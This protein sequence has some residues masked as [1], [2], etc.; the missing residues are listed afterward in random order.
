MDTI[1]PGI[2]YWLV[3]GLLWGWFGIIVETFWTMLRKFKNKLFKLPLF[4]PIRRFNRHVYVA[5]LRYIH[6]PL[7]ERWLVWRRIHRVETKS[8]AVSG[9]KIVKKEVHPHRRSPFSLFTETNGW[10]FIMFATGMPLLL[11][12]SKHLLQYHMS[13]CIRFSLYALGFW[14]AELLWGTLI[15]KLGARVP[16]DYSAAKWS[17]CGGLIRLDYFPAWGALGLAVEH[18][19]SYWVNTVFAPA[20]LRGS[21]YMPRLLPTI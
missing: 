20:V 1:E 8:V 6:Q 13:R 2:N 12:L 10:T 19:F 18:F 11:G 3:V 15:K 17:A 4:L 21:E 16:W 5:W 7:F 14:G 9:K